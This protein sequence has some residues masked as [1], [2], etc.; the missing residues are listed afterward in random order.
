MQPCSQP[1]YGL[2]ERS[3]PTSG[4]WLR[5]M[6]FLAVSM[7][8]TVWNGAFSH[9]SGSPPQPSSVL[10]RSG[11]SNRP[12]GRLVTAPRP[13]SGTSRMTSTSVL[14]TSLDMQPKIGCIQELIGILRSEAFA[15]HFEDVARL[16]PLDQILQHRLH[17]AALGFG[18]A[19]PLAQR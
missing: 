11:L 10:T 18:E 8:S 12:L 3:K 7:P 9:S 5:V 17:F 14:I 19:A 13:L 6:I 16:H 15:Q 4:D 1:L 2:I